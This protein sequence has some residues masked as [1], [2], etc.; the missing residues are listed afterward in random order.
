MADRSA[1]GG[2][3][4]R[5]WL[6]WASDTRY[7]EASAEK[8]CAAWAGGG[9]A[10]SLSAADADAARFTNEVRSLPMWQDL[11]AVRLRQA[12]QASSDLLQAV[13]AYLESPSD[14]TA[15]LVE[16]AGDLGRPAAAWKKILGTIDSRPCMPRSARD[17]I[18]QRAGEAGFTVRPDAASA[19]EDWASGDFARLASALDLLFL[20]RAG[21]GSVEAEDLEALLGAGG[22]PR[23][24]D[25]Q[26]AFLKRDR[27]NFVRLVHAI[28][29]DGDAVPLAVVGM[30]ARQFRALLMF[31]S[32]R[33]RGVRPQEITARM[34]GLNY[35]W[36]ARKLGESAARWPER[37]VRETLGRLY[38]LDLA[39]KGD[40]GEP[41][42]IFERHLLKA[43]A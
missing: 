20:Y 14:K 21:E 15:L 33:A 28:Q 3:P 2:K 29:R 26:D 36:Q 1:S 7:L 30:L 5:N 37:S 19:L 40:P 24:W 16:Y 27:K 31:H 42:A 23:Q 17:L 10:V 32:Q 43:M 6:L 35:D 22:T 41:W 34:L 25:V 8:W 4:P 12:E 11:Q 9:D 39:L 13:A 18:R 38:D